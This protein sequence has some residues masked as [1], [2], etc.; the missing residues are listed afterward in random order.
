MNRHPRA[1][2]V[3]VLL[4]AVSVGAGC[5]GG[6]SEKPAPGGSSSPGGVRLEFWHTRRGDQEKSLQAICDEYEKATP[7]VEIEPVYQ[8][9]YGE[10]NKKTRAAIQAKSLPDLS[11]AYEDHVSE[12]MANQV[13]RPLD[14][15]IADSEVGLSEE[16]RKDIPEQYMA[17]NRYARF[18][19]QLLSFPF[20]KSNL[21]MYYNRS[22]MEKAGL[23]TPPKTWGEFE[24]QAAAITKANGK[25]AYVFSADASTLDGMIYSYGGKILDP[26]SGKT[27]FDEPAT[28]R[29][30]EMLQRMAKAGTLQLA[31]GDDAGNLFIGQAAAFGTDT[32]A[33]R[34]YFEIQI[35]KTFDWDITMIPHAEGAEPATV[36]YGPNVILFKSTPEQEREAWKF[37]RYFTS[38][39][40]TAR[41]ARETG[42]LPVRKSAVEQPEMQ[43]F[44][45]QNARARHVYE[46]L[47]MAKPEPNVVGWQEVRKLL[48]DTARS[49]ITAGTSPAAAAVDLKKKADA[50]LAASA[51]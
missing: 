17:A 49:V 36:M 10:L 50:A 27:H 5:G 26:K 31:S 39:P 25:P 20:T 35:D 48:E 16:E 6:S 15:L 9:T 4:V 2:T 34:A 23:K 8:G 33:S 46:I 43:Q 18:N 51:Q 13:I 45:Q 24:Q 38:P 32:S 28:V 47:P 40:V 29:L 3:A 41:W 1:Q 42:Y 37:V 11:V 19:N 14:D 21:V 22:L 7:G 44:Y 30:L 12:Y